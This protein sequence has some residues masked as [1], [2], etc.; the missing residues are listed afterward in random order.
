MFDAKTCVCVVCVCM[1]A[2]NPSASYY[3]VECN[4]SLVSCLYM[5]LQ[6]HRRIMIVLVVHNNVLSIILMQTTSLLTRWRHL[7]LNVLFHQ[8]QKLHPSHYIFLK[9]PKNNNN[10]NKK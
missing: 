3:L 1:C 6:F 9:L 7:C 4:Q 5:H 8:L 10:N 2:C